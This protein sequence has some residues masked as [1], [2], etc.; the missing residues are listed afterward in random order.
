[1]DSKSHFGASLTVL[2][3]PWNYNTNE[4]GR[5]RETRGIPSPLGEYRTVLPTEELL[6]EAIEQTRRQLQTRE[7]RRRS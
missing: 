7:R 6:A 3:P 2:A 4:R 1:M 5:P